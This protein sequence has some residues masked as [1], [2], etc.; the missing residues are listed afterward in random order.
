MKAVG[1]AVRAVYAIF[2]VPVFPRCGKLSLELFFFVRG[3]I[4]KCLF[5]IYGR[6]NK[7]SIQEGFARRAAGLLGSRSLGLFAA[8]QMMKS[9][10]GECHAECEE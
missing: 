8:I 7:T 4:S 5:N 3:F 10:S 2:K 9:S 1:Q 6:V